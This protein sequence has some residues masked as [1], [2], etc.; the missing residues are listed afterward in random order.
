MKNDRIMNAASAAS[1]V[2]TLPFWCCQM[3]VQEKQAA[4]VYA[5][6]NT[7]PLAERVLGF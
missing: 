6:K 4:S 3:K 7:G 2:Q 5:Q 1:F